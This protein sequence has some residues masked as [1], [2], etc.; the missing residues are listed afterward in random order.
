MSSTFPKR[1]AMSFIAQ[2]LHNVPRG[3]V[4]DSG[5]EEEK[6][7]WIGKYGCPKVV[8]VPLDV[9]NRF[10]D[11]A[12]ARE[13]GRYYAQ[14]L[15]PLCDALAEEVAEPDENETVFFIDGEIFG[16]VVAKTA[17]LESLYDQA[18]EK[19][20]TEDDRVTGIKRSASDASGDSDGSDDPDVDGASPTKKHKDTKTD[21]VPFVV[22]AFDGELAEPTTIG[23]GTPVGPGTF[24]V[25]IAVQCVDKGHAEAARDLIRL[26]NAFPVGLDDILASFGLADLKVTGE[27]MADALLGP[28]RSDDAYVIEKSILVFS[29]YAPEKFR[30][31]YEAVAFFARVPLVKN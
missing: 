1:S 18:M 27:I 22:I 26:S 19:D 14:H 30:R 4:R 12:K 2:P 6:I 10:R 31:F 16:I 21:L 5:W 23:T 28:E 3:E 29:S 20:R 24:E 11:A 25:A 13:G 17:E 9:V 15:E 7:I 8:V